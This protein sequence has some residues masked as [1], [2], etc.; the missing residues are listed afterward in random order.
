MRQFRSVLAIAQSTESWREGP[1]ISGYSEINALIF[2]LF[3]VSD[4]HLLPGCQS[5]SL[6]GFGVY[7]VA[8]FSELLATGWTSAGHAHRGRRNGISVP[9][10]QHLYADS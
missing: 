9:Q 1:Y 10:W 2:Q 3:T 4:A 8:A 5:F 7:G 6:V